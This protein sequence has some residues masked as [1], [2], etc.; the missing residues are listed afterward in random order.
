MLK[1]TSAITILNKVTANVKPVLILFTT[2][3][4]TKFIWRFLLTP[5]AWNAAQSKTSPVLQEDCLRADSCQ[6][7]TKRIDM[8]SS[9]CVGIQ[10]E[11]CQISKV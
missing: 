9:S 1:Y 2:T 5:P 6:D 8:L 7:C 4:Q 11:V 3:S 10:S